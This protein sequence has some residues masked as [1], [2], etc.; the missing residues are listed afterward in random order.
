MSCTQGCSKVVSRISSLRSPWMQRKWWYSHSCIMV[1]MISNLE[2]DVCTIIVCV[3]YCTRGTTVTTI[4][5]EKYR[6]LINQNWYKQPDLHKREL[7]NIIM[8]GTKFC[9]LTILVQSI[10]LNG[11]HLNFLQQYQMEF[12]GR[13]LSSI[14]GSIA[15]LDL[16]C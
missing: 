3:A 1:V 10:V 4:I 5:V 2:R 8:Q 16:W 14:W 11:V 9:G 7:S 15:K 13:Q 6:G 12:I